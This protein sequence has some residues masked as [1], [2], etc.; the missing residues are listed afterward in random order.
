MLDDI[1]V[2]A[3]AATNNRGLSDWVQPLEP[4]NRGLQQRSG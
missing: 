1:V 2:V 3:I 4:S